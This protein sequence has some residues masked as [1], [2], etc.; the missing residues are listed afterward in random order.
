M[1]CFCPFRPSL[2]PGGLV[3]NCQ[4]RSA[5]L[6]LTRVRTQPGRVNFWMTNRSEHKCHSVL[7]ADHATP[8]A[9]TSDQN[10][11]NPGL[12][13]PVPA[14]EATAGYRRQPTPGLCGPWG[15]RAPGS[16]KATRDLRLPTN[17]AANRLLRAAASLTAHPARS[18]T[19]LG[20]ERRALGPCSR[21]SET[22]GRQE[23][24]TFAAAPAKIP[25][26]RA[27]GRLWFKGQVCSD[28]KEAPRRESKHGADRGQARPGPEEGSPPGPPPR[29]SLALPLLTDGPWVP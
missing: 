8:G 25:R 28:R 11:Q 13:Q 20:C 5:L 12:T 1:T 21:V 23:K 7:T 9:E 6:V 14:A 26:V 19:F 27:P 17:V 4:L 18:H 3:S 15:R 10:R 22:G 2:W 16:Q 29:A 24:D